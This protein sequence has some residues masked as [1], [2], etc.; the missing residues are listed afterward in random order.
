MKH[1]SAKKKKKKGFPAKMSL[2][3]TY[4]TYL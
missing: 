2:F 1:F 4:G 3:G